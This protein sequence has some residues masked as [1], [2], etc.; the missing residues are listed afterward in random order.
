MSEWSED[1][2]SQMK[3]TKTIRRATRDVLEKGENLAFEELHDAQSLKKLKQ[4]IKEES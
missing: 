4:M 2:E 3:D 1:F